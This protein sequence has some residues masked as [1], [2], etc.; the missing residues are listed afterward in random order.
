MK[1]ADYMEMAGVTDEEL[2]EKIGLDR[3]TVTRLRNG[4][5]VPSFRSLERIH[6]AT[7]GAVTFCD[8]TAIT[9]SGEAT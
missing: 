8:F 2:A 9:Q 5:A 7:R 4:R 1:L 3:S 6:V